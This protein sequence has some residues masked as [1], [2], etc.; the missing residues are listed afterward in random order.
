MTKPAYISKI[1]SDVVSTRKKL[2]LATELLTS[3]EMRQW[4]FD[5]LHFNDLAQPP[6]AERTPHQLFLGLFDSWS[7]E[8]KKQF[9][10]I[11]IDF[12]E[13]LADNKSSDWFG[14][15]GVELL[16]LFEPGIFPPSKELLRAVAILM[17]IGK[18]DVP[19]SDENDYNPNLMA[20]GALAGLNAP[21][22]K[23]FWLG[24]FKQ[25]GETHINHVF[26]GLVLIDIEYAFNWLASLP[27]SI[28]VHNTLAGSLPSV[29]EDYRERVQ[30][31]PLVRRVLENAPEDTKQEFLDAFF[32]E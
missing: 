17:R 10:R 12:A 26:L 28:A 7:S 5:R 23:R 15:P 3:E 2:A 18:S 32:P 21:H 30:L 19:M 25:H 11:I 31:E 27:W 14:E 4:I 24:I 13:N 1:R 16:L 9:R 20:L 6:D 8:T 29:I 22:D